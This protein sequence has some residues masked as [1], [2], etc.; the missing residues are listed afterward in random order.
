[1]DPQ[2]Y[3]TPTLNPWSLGMHDTKCKA[4][5]R[6]Q[7]ISP[8]LGRGVRCG[9]YTV[10]PQSFRDAQDPCALV[11]YIA[12]YIIYMQY[13]IYVRPKYIIYFGL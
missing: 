6:I 7:A 8:R 11:R 12:T 10:G 5:L 1:M 13:I 9:L 3:M 2:G 4:G